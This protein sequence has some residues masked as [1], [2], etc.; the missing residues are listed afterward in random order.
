MKKLWIIVSFVVLLGTG[1]VAYNTKVNAQLGTVI[2]LS[3][4]AKASQALER[5]EA[6]EKRVAQ[7]EKSL[8]NLNKR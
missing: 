2:G 5:I 7:L 6:L 4:N 3:A 8:S 1:I